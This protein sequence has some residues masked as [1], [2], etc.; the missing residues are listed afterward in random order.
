[1]PSAVFAWSF[2]KRLFG[3]IGRGKEAVASVPS[4]YD[5]VKSAGPKP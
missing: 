4:G 5:F 2:E 1:M 3:F